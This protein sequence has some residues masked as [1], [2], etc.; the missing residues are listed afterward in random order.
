M[1]K[2]TAHKKLELTLFNFTFHFLEI[3]EGARAGPNFVLNST[4]FISKQVKKRYIGFAVNSSKV[5]STL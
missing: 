5:G 3:L 1:K 2:Q 4:F